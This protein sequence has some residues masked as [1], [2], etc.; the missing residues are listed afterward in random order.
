MVVFSPSCFCFVLVWFCFSLSDYDKLQ[1]ACSSVHGQEKSHTGTGSAGH[2]QS[3]CGVAEPPEGCWHLLPMK[4]PL[5]HH[6][7]RLPQV[8]ISQMDEGGWMPCPGSGNVW[9]SKRAAQPSEAGRRMMF[10]HAQIYFLVLVN[11]IYI[12]P[13]L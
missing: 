12:L 4:P 13:T 8:C 10:Y 1:V 6:H 9:P 3:P 11:G 2:V 7:L 5:S